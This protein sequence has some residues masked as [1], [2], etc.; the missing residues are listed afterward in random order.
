MKKKFQDV[1]WA[2]AKNVAG[3]AHVARDQLFTNCD[4]YY[5]LGYATSRGNV[6]SYYG[7]TAAGTRLN[8]KI[9]QFR[10]NKRTEV[11]INW[12]LLNPNGIIGV[13]G[14]FPYF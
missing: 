2:L 11:S 4:A 14:K 10:L 7:V 8:T 3:N 13:I 9:A 12:Y 1:I 6:R 5:S